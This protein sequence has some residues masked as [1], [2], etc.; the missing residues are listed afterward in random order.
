[1]RNAHRLENKVAIITGGSR[2]IGRAVGVLFAREGASLV[3]NHLGDAEQAAATLTALSDASAAEGHGAARHHV[4]EADVA[5]ARAVERMF[6]ELE[7]RYERFDILVNNAG[8]QVPTPGEAFDEAEF[9]RVLAVD[10]VGPALCARAA[11]KHFLA[12]PGGGTII[13]T[14]SAHERI[15]KPGYAAY[16]IAK[17]GLG[18]LTRTL[19]LEFAAVGIRVNAVAPGAV[20]TDMNAGWI[21]DPEMRASVESHIPLGRAADAEEIAPLYAFLASDESRYITGQT[22]YACG[23]VTLYADFRKN[24]AS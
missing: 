23:G 21:N 7:A 2:G 20:A 4:I 16:A 22:I 18:S 10:L 24:W 11:L 6:V 3:I 19:A 5:D 1:M 17:G 9:S 14:T 12:R 13:N 15:P 8:F